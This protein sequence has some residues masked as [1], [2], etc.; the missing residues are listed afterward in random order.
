MDAWRIYAE[1]HGSLGGLSIPGHHYCGALVF[2]AK[3]TPNDAHDGPP[4]LAQKHLEEARSP[5]LRWYC[6]EQDPI[7]RQLLLEPPKQVWPEGAAY[8][9]KEIAP[10]DYKGNIETV[11]TLNKD[12][13][14]VA[15]FEE[16]PTE[17]LQLRLRFRAR[18]AEAKEI[19]N[20]AVAKWRLKKERLKLD[21]AREKPLSE[22]VDVAD[23]GH[24][25]LN[26]ATMLYK[27]TDRNSGLRHT[28]L[29]NGEGKPEN[30]ADSSRSLNYREN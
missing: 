12:K 30:E 2:A 13:Q 16:S 23:L 24:G 22:S 25:N 8:L 18:K 17:Q 3:M 29:S 11:Y 6:Q 19:A 26:M 20:K 14:K 28:R 21:R 9:R 7:E 5:L 4:E 1:Y 27:L 15:Q 10:D